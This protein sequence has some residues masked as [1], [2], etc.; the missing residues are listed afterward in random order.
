MKKY[1][2]VF[3]VFGLCTRDGQLRNQED[4]FDFIKEKKLDK[5][6]LQQWKDP[7]SDYIWCV[8]H[9]GNLNGDIE[10]VVGWIMDNDD[11]RFF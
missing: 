11:K 8:F 10:E 9:D 3:Y 2:N 1:P 5:A 7:D 4:L 6:C